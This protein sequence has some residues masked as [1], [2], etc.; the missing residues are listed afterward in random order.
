MDAYALPG[1][2]LV[3][4]LN[5]VW[6]PDDGDPPDGLGLSAGQVYLA[7]RRSDDLE[8]AVKIYGRPVSTEKDRLR[9]EQE[10]AAL[11]ALADLPHLLAPLDA[12]VIDGQ[13][14]LVSPFCPSG[15]LQDHLV[16][17]GRLTATEVRRIG[18]KLADS[19]A[20]AHEQGLYHRNLK[21]SNVL[22]D[23]G[24]EPQLA[25]FGLVS[26]ALAGGDYQLPDG[27]R[28]YAAPEAFL[29][30]LM[31]AA[32]DIY[33][34]GATLYALLAGTSPPP[35]VGPVADLPTV[36][37]VIMHVIRRAMAA[38][39]LERYPSAAGMRDALANTQPGSARVPATRP[40]TP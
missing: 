22:V 26:L 15:S 29:P 6:A 24:G 21:P 2:D 12:G 4:R 17:V 7:R 18:V 3:R 13:A 40:S 38:D 32:T 20:R 27:P 23:S 33:A 16:T 1:V 30:E 36:P 10:A 5:A 19:L 14:Y 11:K 28:P 8:V 37:R 9:F 31:T 35:T 25:D 39:P 34:L